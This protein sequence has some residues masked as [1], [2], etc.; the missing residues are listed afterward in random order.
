MKSNSEVGHAKNLANF[1]KLIAYCIGFGVLYLP[2]KAILQIANMQQLLAD[3]RIALTIVTDRFNT[4]NLAK[5]ARIATFN[6]LIPLTDRIIATLLASDASD[7]TKEDAR[8]IARKIKGIRASK[9]TGAAAKNESTSVETKPDAAEDAP[10]STLENGNGTTPRTRST[11][12]TSRDQLIEHFARLL[13]LLQTEI[14]Y[15]PNEVEL[16]LPTLQAFL[17]TM[18]MTNSAFITAEVE[19]SNARVQ[20]TQLLYGDKTGICD[21][22]KDVKLYVKG[23]FKKDSPQY[24]Q[25]SSLKFVKFKK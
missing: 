16:Q 10:A 17:E 18:R 5:N 13:A 14:A 9:K 7:K 6:Q 15:M 1:E 25:I 20:R 2:M 11:A 12:Q 4:Y 8:A 21:V 22:A 19:W 24:K 3:A 23:A